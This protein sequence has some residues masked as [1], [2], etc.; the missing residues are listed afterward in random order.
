MFVQTNTVSSVKKYI[1]EK[2]ENHFSDS[3][4]KMMSN[5]FLK[6]RL[7]LS[8]SDLIASSDILVTESDLLYFRSC[9]KRLLSE[10]PFQHIV[11]TTFFYGLEFKVDTRA[12]IPRP[13]TE[14]L[15]DWIVSDYKEQSNLRIV[16]LCTGS[17]CVAISLKSIL[18]DASIEAIDYS[19]DALGL[20]KENSNYTNLTVQFR[21][22]D[23]LIEDAFSPKLFI[24]E[25][26]DCWVSN[27]PYIPNSDKAKMS[28][29][30]LDF[31]PEMALFVS[32]TEPLIFYSK[33][34]KD[35][36]RFLKSKG[37]LYFEI[38]EDLAKE[39][40]EL[41]SELDYTS[42]EVKKDLQ[43]KDRMVKAVKR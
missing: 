22:L 5:E 24:E 25:S 41:L 27:P 2:L 38:H 30:V 21:H 16:D 32:D 9:V 17:G 18:N 42:I 29:N 8:H 39:V 26:Y 19:L 28:R 23:V 7:K 15:V 3:E 34:A 36:L 31:E 1:K 13:E 14:E 35:A 33:I 6:K 4:I 12:L 10:E 37:H 20:A 43:G 11:G 40:V